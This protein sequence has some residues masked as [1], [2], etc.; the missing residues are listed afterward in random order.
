MASTDRLRMRP[1]NGLSPEASLSSTSSKESPARLNRIK[2]EPGAHQ[3]PL[4]LTAP[5]NCSVQTLTCTKGA[6]GW[7]KAGWG[8]EVRS[9]QNGSGET[10]CVHHHHCWLAVQL[11]YTASA[12]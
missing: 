5:P 11:L 3:V 6:G 2:R 7:E 4:R 9:S 1:I 8:D 10:S 12:R